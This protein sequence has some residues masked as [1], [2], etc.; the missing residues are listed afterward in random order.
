MRVLIL[1]AG[2]VWSS[3]AA[4]ISKICKVY[5]VWFRD[6]FGAKGAGL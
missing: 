3:V 4:M 2:H 5:V 6:P 1:G